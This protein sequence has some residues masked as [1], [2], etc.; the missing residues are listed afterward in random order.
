MV[1]RLEDGFLGYL[2]KATRNEEDSDWTSHTVDY[3]V[4][5]RILKKIC[6]R[7]YEIRSMLRKSPDGK[8]SEEVVAQVLGTSV[9]VDFC[10]RDLPNPESSEGAGDE[11]AN[12]YINLLGV[13]GVPSDL[14]SKPSWPQDEKPK[15][16]N[17]ASVLRT[18]A[19]LERKELVVFLKAEMDKV[20]MFYLSQWQRVSHMMELLAPT[21]P[22]YY[23]V[24]EEILELVAFCVINIVAVC[25]ILIRYDGYARTYEAVPI[26]DY[27]IKHNT[28]FATPFRKILQHEE[29]VALADS[30]EASV[31]HTPLLSN[32]DS[33]RRMF[34]EILSATKTARVAS[35][36]GHTLFRDSVIQVLRSWILMGSYED[37][38]GL[39]PS[40]LMMRGQSL[41][42]EM[43]R[44]VEWRKKKHEILPSPTIKK[45]S[46][47]GI[48]VFNL[49]LNLLSGFLYC[50]NYYIVEP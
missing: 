26:L 32:F 20:Q 45:K 2:E 15:R 42:P 13:E 7:R 38:L 21:D 49:T 39:E 11:V 3:S 29:L 22:E 34:M 43:R 50:M 35:S 14:D 30:F 37:R 19:F 48:Q 1:I 16:R 40:Y 12:N 6:R 27:W 5:K 41:K 17:R 44:L 25:Q 24:G 46:L 4:F 31:E 8:L 36:S 18:L 23:T 47:T 28:R 9:L 33:Q 10:E